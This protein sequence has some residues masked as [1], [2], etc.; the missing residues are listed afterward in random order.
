MALYT[1]NS[2]KSIFF[3]FWGIKPK[4]QFIISIYSDMVLCANTAIPITPSGAIMNIETTE[5][6][7]PIDPHGSPRLRGIPPLQPEQ[8]MA[9]IKIKSIIN[10]NKGTHN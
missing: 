10:F 2:P 4:W 3:Y 7:S 9:S 5:V 8:P 1:L 6:V